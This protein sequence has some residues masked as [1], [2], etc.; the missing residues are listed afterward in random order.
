[1]SNNNEDKKISRTI[2]KKINKNR[3]IWKK[4]LGSEQAELWL[5]ECESGG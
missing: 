3:R 1:M 4:N 5:E 2:R